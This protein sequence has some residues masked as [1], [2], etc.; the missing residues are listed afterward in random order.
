MNNKSIESL[1]F[2]SDQLN[3]YLAPIIFLS[4]TVGNIMNCLVLSQRTLRSNPCAF[5]FL[6][7]SFIDLISI[8]IGLPTRILA[9]WHLDPT[10]T[11]NWACKTR[12][13]IVFSTR[14][15]AIW[16]IALA[17]IDRW[18]ISSIDIH[19]RHMSNLKNVKR[20]IFTIVIL[21]ILFYIH[22][23]PCY[24]ANNID[25]PLKCYEKTE[26]CHLVTDLIYVILSLVMPLVLM[27]IF[28]LLTISHI[29]RLHTRVAHA[30]NNLGTIDPIGHANLHSKKT[31]HHLL[32]M[33]T[34]Q[35]LLLIVLYI[36]QAIQKFYITF[37][38]FGS[39]SV[40]ED[41]IKTFLY[42]IDV[43]L[44]FMASAM[45]FYIYVLAGGSVFQKALMNLVRLV[46]QKMAY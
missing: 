33:L 28:G 36:P 17:T 22:M 46:K 15:M 31:D 10:N 6:A 2:I 8:L 7:S 44:A 34:L 29:H 14:T 12:A 26:G 32:R 38:P 42:N 40:L 24:E 11:I 18:L 9:G 1:D 16:L 35:V 39:G 41:A 37:K 19:R 45:P 5:L 20:E 4:G 25:A 3:K 21:S 43:L 27:I 30:G 13:F 23:F